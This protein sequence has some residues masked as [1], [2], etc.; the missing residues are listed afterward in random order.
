MNMCNTNEASAMQA[1]FAGES[2]PRI[3]ELEDR[4]DILCAKNGTDYVTDLLHSHAQ[5][6]HDNGTFKDET[7]ASQAVR[8]VLHRI[9]N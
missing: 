5:K 4:F 6:L 3:N 1:F 8:A 7:E 2:S 9:A